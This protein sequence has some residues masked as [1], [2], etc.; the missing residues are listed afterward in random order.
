[1]AV[2]SI[3]QAAL[4]HSAAVREPLC[5]RHG[6]DFVP[7]HACFHSTAKHIVGMLITMGSTFWLNNLHAPKKMN[8]Q[9][10]QMHQQKH[11]MRIH[12]HTHMYTEVDILWSVGVGADRD[13]DHFFIYMRQDECF[14]YMRKLNR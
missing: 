6:A 9:N 1:M 5:M 10:K 13:V 8:A 4:P 11:G 2:C 12:I 7:G 14:M 3:L